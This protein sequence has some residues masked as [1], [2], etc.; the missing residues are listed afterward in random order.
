M[1]LMTFSIS[2]LLRLD[3]SI[4]FDVDVLVGLEGCGSIGGKLHAMSRSA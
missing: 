3:S 1:L 4:L 2:P